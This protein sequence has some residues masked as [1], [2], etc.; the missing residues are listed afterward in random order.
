MKPTTERK[1]SLLI[2][3]ALTLHIN[4]C[5][6]VD[7]ISLS[8][9]DPIN[10]EELKEASLREIA[11]RYYGKNFHLGIANH[12]KLIGQL[13]TEIADREFSYIVPANDY[14]QSYIH[15][16][17]TRWRWENPD[18]YLQHAK[19]KGQRLRL[20]GPISPQCSPWARDD[21][22]TP[23]E[24]SRML[25]EY[26]TALCM[27]YGN[28]EQ[29]V[30]MDVVNETICPEVVKGGTGFD[31]R[32]PGDWFGP[33]LGTD[34]WENPWTILGYDEQSDIKTPRYIDRAFELANQ[35]APNVKQIINQHGQFEEVVW[36]KMK[37]LVA[38]LRHDKN[39]RVDGLGWQAHVEMGWEKKPGNLERLDAM[40]KWCHANNLEFHI[41]EMNVWMK[42]P[43]TA[44]EKEQADTFEA[45][46]KTILQNRHT[47][48]VG[49]SFWN[50]RDEDTSN[51][52][53]QGNLWRNDG[54]SRP[55]YHRIKQILI[56]NIEIKTSAKGNKH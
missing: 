51:A 44:N 4:A 35:Y 40:I 17:F 47:G 48:T 31:D 12:A 36:E 43:E 1:Y 55:A 16:D 52:S 19:E 6:A 56:D 3:F 50:V 41:T 28:E 2:L 15:P 33:R 8:V 46:F 5:K 23:E 42:N 26:M 14:K 54:S 20:H 53:W 24:L 37:K 49:L 39:R 25:D 45:I 38:Y 7:E 13:S 22:R 30:W 11:D 21:K 29:V 9:Q 10:R 27:R 18:A 34:K 32:K